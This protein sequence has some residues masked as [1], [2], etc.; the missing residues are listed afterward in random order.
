[1][2][3][4]SVNEKMEGQ[5]K[6][7]QVEK[8]ILAIIYSAKHMDAWIHLTNPVFLGAHLLCVNCWIYKER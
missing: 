7:R 5:K 2:F 1:M 4:Q 8:E 3:A 6:E